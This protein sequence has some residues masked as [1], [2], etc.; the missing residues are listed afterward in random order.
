MY[1]SSRKE[2][3][4]KAG[5]ISWIYEL[6]IALIFLLLLLE[7]L[8]EYIK[9]PELLVVGTILLFLMCYVGGLVADALIFG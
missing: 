8:V 1:E 4:W 2:L 7:S 3:V 9:A 6:A 5:S